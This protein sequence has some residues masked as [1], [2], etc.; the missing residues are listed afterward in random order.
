MTTTELPAAELAPAS[1]R[2]PRRSVA[3]AVVCALVVLALAALT[4]WQVVG[5]R[6]HLDSGYATWADPRAVHERG[7]VTGNDIGSTWSID[8]GDG[9]Y[10]S[11]VRNKGR[12]P[13]TLH[14]GTRPGGLKQTIT[15][16][17][18]VEAYIRFGAPVSSITVSP[19][20]EVQVLIRLELCGDD[21]AAGPGSSTSIEGVD[22]EATTW[23]LN[24]KV[25]LDV[26][27]S[28]GFYDKVG[29]TLPPSPD[30]PTFP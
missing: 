16:A 22:V 15:F 11:L 7:D 25:H 30:C 2:R 4:G 5:R 28:Y 27:G 12:V 6:P 21:W 24:R 20:H 13:V 14:G 26:G 19:G 1:P 8:A 10:W 23:G 18:I 17:P 9:T 29:A 3:R